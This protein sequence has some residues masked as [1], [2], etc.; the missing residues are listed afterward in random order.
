MSD[1]KLGELVG[2]GA[3][4][5]AVHVAIVPMR[6]LRLLQPGER[7]TNGIVD[8]FL[9]APVEPGQRF[10]LLL[11]PG[12]V[13]SLRHV[14]EHPAYP[15]EPVPAKKCRSEADVWGDVKEGANEVA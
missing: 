14:W 4:R 6:A 7:L 1:V 15:S 8:P 9:T 5:D 2:D 13:T 12:T 3:G 11:F 10:Y